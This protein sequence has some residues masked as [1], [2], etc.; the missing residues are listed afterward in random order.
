M[1]PELTQT[2]LELLDDQARMITQLVNENVE[3]ENVI[4]ALMRE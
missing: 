3:Q 4:N 1:S 2:L